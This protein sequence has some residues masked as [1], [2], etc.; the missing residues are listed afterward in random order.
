MSKEIIKE[1]ATVEEAQALIAAEFGVAEDMITFEVVHQPGKKVLGLFGGANAIV[2]GT[3]AAGFAADAAKAYL[4]QVLAAMGVTAFT[5]TVKEENDQCVLSLEGE[6]LGFIIGRRG[7]TLDALQYLTGLVANRVDNSYYR[8]TL[9]IG[10]YREKREQ[11][12]VGLARR[13]GG[14]TARTGRRHSLE[15]MNPYERRIIHTA[16]QD[17]EGVTSWSV[18]SEPNRHVIIGP[19]DDN[20]N[21]DKGGEGN[22]RN[23]NGR[24]GRGR[25][26]NGG[27][28]GGNSGSRGERRERGAHREHEIVAPDRPVRE[29]I[30]RSNPMPMADGGTPPSRTES[31]KEQNASLYGRIDL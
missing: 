12:L 4:E 24:G 21:K 6:D 22:R 31:E 27:G 20:P 29:F 14:Q 1:A 28:R 30:S 5:C 16:V 9:D 11:A 23:R 26:G 25:G 15:P 13:L 10:N 8:V 17:I 18:G 19:T 3:L 7:E 2:K